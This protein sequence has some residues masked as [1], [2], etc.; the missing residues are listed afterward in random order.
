MESV[1]TIYNLAVGVTDDMILGRRVLSALAVPLSIVNLTESVNLLGWSAGVNRIN[2]LSKTRQIA[3][4]YDRLEAFQCSWDDA[5]WITRRIE[6][7]TRADWKEIVA[8]TNTP[9][10]V[11]QIMLEKMISRRNSLVQHFGLASTVGLLP[12]TADRGAHTLAAACGATAASVK[13]AAATGA[14]LVTA[15]QQFTRVLV[16]RTTRRRFVGCKAVAQE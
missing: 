15:V 4:A 9:K 7:L 1:H 13:S 12:V 2:D 16:E 8:S 5:R 10:A 11:Q 6:K 3:L 14:A